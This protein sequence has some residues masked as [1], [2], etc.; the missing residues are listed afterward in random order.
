MYGDSLRDNIVGVIVVD[1]DKLA[2]FA[3][4]Q[5]KNVSDY[6][7]DDT[8]LDG[9]LKQLILEDLLRLAKANAFTSLEKP[10]D[11]ILTTE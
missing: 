10:K 7:N 11:L 6:M 8:L 9:T 5:G 3:K 4:T 2:V 1:P